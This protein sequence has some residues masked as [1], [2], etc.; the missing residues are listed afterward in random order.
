MFIEKS[1]YAHYVCNYEDEHGN[2]SYT[3]EYYSDRPKDLILTN[4]FVKELHRRKGLGNE[5]LRHVTEYAG[6]AGFEQLFVKVGY[7]TWQNQWYKR[8]G[9]VFH[10]CDKYDSCYVWLVK[11]IDL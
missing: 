10:E 11:Q 3:L 5:I 7:D 1:K 4:V 8:H 9:F 6:N 2:S